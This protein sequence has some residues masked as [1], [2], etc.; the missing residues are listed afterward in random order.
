MPNILILGA[1]GKLGRMTVSALADAASQTVAILPVSRTTKTPITWAP[2][3]PISSDLRADVVIALWGITPEGGGDLSLNAKL[4][5]QAIGLAETVGADRVLHCSSVAVY[6]PAEASASECD[7]LNPANPY[8]QAKADMEAAIAAVDSP[9]QS[10]SM[11]IGNVAGA[12]GLFKSI[13]ERGR[14][15]LDQFPDGQGPE[16]FYIAPTDFARVLMALSLCDLEQLPKLINVAAPKPTPMADLVRAAGKPLD[17]KPAPEGA[18]QHV[19]ID[20]TLLKRLC[21]LPDSSADADW[22]VADWMERTDR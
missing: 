11:R 2:G 12:D 5:E 13:R 1:N 4:A 19:G 21:P 15:T 22:L 9:V 14:I 17:W 6:E 8:G 18:K 7:S 16:R 3:D 10:C 20:T